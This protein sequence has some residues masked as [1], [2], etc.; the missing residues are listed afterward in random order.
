[1]EYIVAGSLI[2]T[3]AVLLYKRFHRETQDEVEM[4]IYNTIK[5]LNPV[6]LHKSVQTTYSPM[7]V[8]EQYSPNAK[9]YFVENRKAKEF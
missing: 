6:R 3:A 4:V 5:P 1:M 7:K 8:V 2:F 9:Y